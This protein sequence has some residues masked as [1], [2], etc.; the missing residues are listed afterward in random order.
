MPL[1][2]RPFFPFF[3]TSSPFFFFFNLPPFS[4]F[5]SG[6]T[7]VFFFESL[8]EALCVARGKGKSIYRRKRATFIWNQPFSLFLSSPSFRVFCIWAE[9][10]RAIFRW[11]ARAPMWRNF[12]V[13][14]ARFETRR[15]KALGRTR[16]ERL[17]L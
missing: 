5:T 8:V 15:E 4:L 12:S 6:W 7:R 13:I 3:F 16:A 17:L 14:C 11:N 9:I 2:F 10:S 1:P